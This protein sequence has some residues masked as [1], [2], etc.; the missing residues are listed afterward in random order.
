MTGTLEPSKYV[1]NFCFFPGLTDK[2]LYK[3]ISGI[4]FYVSDHQFQWTCDL[5]SQVMKK[6]RYLG[7]SENKIYNII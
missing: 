2:I 5:S 3:S 1:N 7:V 6:I 4:I